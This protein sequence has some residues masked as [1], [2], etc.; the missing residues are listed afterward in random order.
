MRCSPSI[1][2]TWAL[3][4]ASLWASPLLYGC[5]GKPAPQGEA[6]H[7]AAPKP[8]P[9]FQ[10]EVPKGAAVVNAA[11]V[12]RYGGTLVLASAGDIETLNPL[13][14]Q[15]TDILR[16]LVYAQGWEFHAKSQSERPG[17]CASYTRS[18]DGL[19]YIFTL[20]EGLRWSDGHPLTTD[21]YL[22]SYALITDPQITTPIQ[23][24]FQQKDQAGQPRYPII[25]KLDDLSFR[26]TLHQPD[27]LFHFTVG[28]LIVLPKHQWA[29]P[30]KSKPF[31]EL[32][33]LD[34]PPSQLISSGPYRIKEVVPSQ[35]IVLERNPYFWKIDS[36][37]NRLP[38]IDEILFKVVPDFNVS[39]MKFLNGE[40]DLLEVRPEQLNTLRQH[41]NRFVIKDLGPAFA[42][43]YL[44]F[45][46]NTRLKPD[47]QPYLSEVKQR[48]FNNKQFR[49][50]ISYAI[51][52]AGI[53]RTALNRR[54]R[55]LWAFYSPAN[56]KWHSNKVTRYPYSPEKAK[57]ILESEGF[58]YK[59]GKLYDAQGV[60]VAFT[61]LTNAEN[62]TRVRMLNVIQEDLRVLGMDVQIQPRPFNELL[63]SLKHGWDYDGL[64]L[65]WGTAVPP[66][67]AQSKNVI[68]S[69]GV[70]HYWSPQQPSPATPWEARIDALIH[71][72][73]G[74]YDYAQRKRYMDEIQAILADE[75]PQIPLV[76]EHHY[77]AARAAIGNFDPTPLRPSTYWN[78]EVL[79]FKSPR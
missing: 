32:M 58:K 4:A 72:C 8:S 73:N 57:S 12:G 37:G 64:L 55:P 70:S 53:V 67:P 41:R 42:T 9:P 33:R 60:H 10:G 35:R 56:R 47:G 17:L 44:M 13:L 54:G 7:D 63:N 68:L 36:A 23:D 30:L 75:L 29:E 16:H 38:Y 19:R 78:A 51:D 76:V 3:L 5:R 26:F 11:D 43:T 28:S 71:Q 65:G 66:D 40:T 69:S 1:S 46:L 52:R 2:L 61:L 77:A 14:S 48:W 20:R 34:T 45:N 49:K 39:F 25:D 15:N 27:V 24:L 31:Q 18:E 21:D 59:E 79:Y 50:A 74:V 6:R 22:F 62:A